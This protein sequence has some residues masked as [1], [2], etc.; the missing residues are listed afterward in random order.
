MSD[1]QDNMNPYIIR[2]NLRRKKGQRVKVKIN[3][4]RNKTTN[5]IGIIQDIYPQIFTIYDG[6]KIN[7]Y[8]FSEVI[9]GEV[10]L[11]FL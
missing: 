6:K 5:Y 3:G 8:S 9:N 10:E 7:S 1:S 11:S 4:M 2:D